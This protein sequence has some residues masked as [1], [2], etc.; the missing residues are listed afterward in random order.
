MPTM[1]GT[2][3]R[4][5]QLDSSSGV[6][7]SLPLGLLLQQGAPAAVAATGAT[8]LHVGAILAVVTAANVVAAAAIA[9]IA[10]LASPPPPPPLPPAAAEPGK[11]T[12]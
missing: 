3:F 4:A 6:L 2:V 8:W 7:F 5:A 11:K 10:V 1:A 9:A 12:Q